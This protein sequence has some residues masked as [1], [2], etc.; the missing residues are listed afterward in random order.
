MTW[1]L[2]FAVVELLVARPRPLNIEGHLSGAV[3]I[4]C[5]QTMLR[6]KKNRVKLFFFFLARGELAIRSKDW[7]I[8]AVR[9]INVLWSIVWPCLTFS[10]WM[11][12]P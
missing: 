8:R 7:I 6:E 9:H 3:V 5:F 11:R 12:G 2:F 4:L 1:L 10:K